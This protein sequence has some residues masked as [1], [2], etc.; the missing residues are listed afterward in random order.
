MIQIFKSYVDF[1]TFEP[2]IIIESMCI[3]TNNNLPVFIDPRNLKSIVF[4]FFEINT[5]FVLGEKNL[6]F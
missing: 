2:K 6:G 3:L 4:N 5:F 1:S